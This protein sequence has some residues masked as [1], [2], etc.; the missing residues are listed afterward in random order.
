MSTT[1]FFQKK[2][3]RRSR[4]AMVAFLAGHF[5]YNTMNSWNRASSY[6]Q[7]IKINRIGLT[8]EQND[9]AWDILDADFWNEIRY[10]IDEFT[11]Q[12]NGAYTMGS[13]GRS[14]GYLVLYESRYESTG[15]KSYC[16]CC[17]QQNYKSVYKPAA[18][19]T[20]ESV[21]APAILASGG[22]WVDSQYM[23]IPEVQQ[24]ALSEVEKLTQ[25]RRLKATLKD[26]TANNRCGR[27]GATG[28]RGRVNYGKTPVALQTYAGRGIDDSTDFEDWSM[29]QLKDRVELVCQFDRTCDN[30]RNNFIDLLGS[31]KVVEEVIMVPKTVKVLQA[32]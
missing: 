29:E 27:C 1:A 14:G 21:V 25:I 23:A 22:V 11:Q 28:E 18:A 31:Y 24:F 8:S 9:A 16:P 10:P 2:V 3:D 20:F 26:A 12:M 19:G 17:G 4:D 7:Y 32:A 30:I 6:A 5:R 15:Y 13:N